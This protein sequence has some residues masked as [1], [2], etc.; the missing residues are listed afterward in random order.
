MKIIIL[1]YEVKYLLSLNI[2]FFF[3]TYFTMFLFNSIFTIIIIYYLFFITNIYFSHHTLYNL[4]NIL[5]YI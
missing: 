1:I 5:Y 4:N 3:N 2:Y